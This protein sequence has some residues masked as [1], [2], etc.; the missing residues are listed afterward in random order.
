[1]KAATGW[2]VL[3]LIALA[4]FATSG[5]TFWYGSG[6][7]PLTREELGDWAGIPEGTMPTADR[8]RGLLE[9]ERWPAFSFSGEFR[10]VGDASI[11][12]VQ[13]PG[14]PYNM[15]FSPAPN[16]EIRGRFPYW[17][18]LIPSAR[19]G[20]YV[21]L[22]STDYRRTAA[23]REFRASEDEWGAGL[24]VGDFLFTGEV[25]NAYDWAT[26]QRVA[27]ESSLVLFGWGL[28]YNRIRQVMPVDAS[29]GDALDGFEDEESAQNPVLYNV[30]DG[31]S[32]LFGLLGWGRVNRTRYLQIL[33]IPVP[34]GQAEL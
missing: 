2:V 5:C 14:L 1:M 8:V 13:L 27:A 29:G 28:G 11:L 23:A 30:K 21:F 6:G 16:H 7:G 20:V 12:Y 19:T 32:L 24:I 9:Q 33:W 34:V 3:S 26:D 15:P 17:R 22:P 31:T 25:A 18:H 4:A 10:M